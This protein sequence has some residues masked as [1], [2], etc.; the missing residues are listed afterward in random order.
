MVKEKD[1]FFETKSPSYEAGYGI[2]GIRGKT[3]LIKNNDAIGGTTAYVFTTKRRDEAGDFAN[4]FPIDPQQLLRI[5]K[6]PI[7]AIYLY[8][9]HETNLPVLKIAILDP[10]PGEKSDI[11]LGVL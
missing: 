7:D 8:S 6:C 4:A 3:V 2:T 1:I 11:E 10:M 9:G 5:G